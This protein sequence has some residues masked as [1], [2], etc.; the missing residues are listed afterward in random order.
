MMTEDYIVE[1]KGSGKN[2]YQVNL[3]TYACTCPDWRNNRAQEPQL[4]PRRLCKHLIKAICENGLEGEF[5]NADLQTLYKKKKGYSSNPSGAYSFPALVEKCFG[6]EVT[7]EDEQR[8]HFLFSGKNAYHNLNNFRKYTYNGPTILFPDEKDELRPV[9]DRL[10]WVGLAG[11]CEEVETIEL[12]P[13]LEL[14]ELKEIGA[15]LGESF[16]QRKTG[17]RKL[18]ENEG[19]ETAFA[20]AGFNKEDFF[21]VQPLDLDMLR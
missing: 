4:S 21:Y 17:I 5:P 3:K 14:S 9:C 16:G 19:L 13:L 11:T 12:L 18:T 20:E 8:I 7:P 15:V 10:C 2:P 6:P 1:I